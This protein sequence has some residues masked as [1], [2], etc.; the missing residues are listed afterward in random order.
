MGRFSD[1]PMF[2]CCAFLANIAPL[3]PAIDSGGTN[4]VCTGVYSPALVGEGVGRSF[5]VLDV[6]RARTV[7]LVAGDGRAG[8][9]VSL[10]LRPARVH[11]SAVISKRMAT[12]CDLEEPSSVQ[13]AELR[14]TC[15]ELSEYVF[16]WKKRVLIWG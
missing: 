2:S 13:V 4:A 10:P 9:S 1:G 15:S 5:C 12:F 6:S 16:W 3:M 8:P 7:L 11:L 14:A